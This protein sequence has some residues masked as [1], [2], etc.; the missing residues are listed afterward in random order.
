M[1]RTAPRTRLAAI[2]VALVVAFLL[3]NLA[4]A[5][6]SPNAA[7]GSGTGSPDSSLGS[8][9]LQAAQRSLGLSSTSAGIG[10]EASYTLPSTSVGIWANVS[11]PGATVPSYRFTTMTWD[12]SDGYVLLYGGGNNSVEFGDTWTYLNG[13]WTNITSEVTGAPPSLALSSMAFDPSSQAVILFGGQANNGVQAQTWSYHDKVWSNLTSTVGSAP[14]P[15]A[16]SAMVTDSTDGE[17]VLVGGSLGSGLFGKDIW[18]YKDGAWKNITSL[19]PVPALFAPALVADD[20]PDHGILVFGP[21]EFPGGTVRPVTLIFSGGAWKNLTS[22][23]LVEPPAAYIGEM[24]YL[25]DAGADVL[26]APISYNESG[27][28]YGTSSTWE[29]AGD[30]W[31]NVSAATGEQPQVGV[32]AG[33]TVLP[34]SG[35]LLVFDGLGFEGFYQ[36]T[37]ALAPPPSIQASALPDPVDVGQAVAFTGSFSG[38]FAPDTPSWS[39]GDGATLSGLSASH[40]YTTA[41]LYTANLT[42]RDFA[43]QAGVGPVSVEVNPA[44]TLST[45]GTPTTSSTGSPTVFV[46]VVSGGTAPYTYS[47]SGPSGATSSSAV[48]QETFGSSGSYTAHVEVRDAAGASANASVTATV[49]T[50]S[51]SVTS[52]TGLALLAGIV[53]LAIVAVALG[54]LLMRKGRAPPTPFAGPAGG[55]T[56]APPT[57]PPPGPGPGT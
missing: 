31:K 55:T 40:T 13:T 45:A 8:F 12:S 22:S 6:P 41:G 43:G 27:G 54:V 37:W 23:L 36:S 19:A 5:G 10:S 35:A 15:R 2:V 11:V 30:V 33:F 52:G 42:V 51:A 16:I 48:L 17:I 47:W 7:G 53:V 46:V 1:R 26:F 24:A 34:G 49:S 25:P 50:A 28:L 18:T 14:S 9:Q 20:P 32:A 38:G 3:P 4:D 39:F 56:S 29:F 57:P 44:L 21:A